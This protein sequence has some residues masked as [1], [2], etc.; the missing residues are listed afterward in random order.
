STITFENNSFGGTIY[1]W[2]FGIDGI[3]SDTSNEINPT[4]TFPDTG[5]YTVTLTVNPG[6]SCGD[7]TIATVYVFPTLTPSILAPDGCVGQPVQL[8]D[9][10]INTYGNLDSWFWNFDDSS[11]SDLINPEHVFDTAGD[12]TIQLIVGNSVGCEDTIEQLI[13]IFP[14]P[15]IN[16]TP[17]DTVICYLDN[18]SLL[19]SAIG[20]T[21]YNW[22]PDYNL[23]TTNTATTLA[24]PDESVTYTVT[25]SNSFGCIAQDSV[26]IEVFDTL[27]AFAGR[28]TTICPG[29]AVQLNGSGGINFSWSPPTGLN[30]TSIANPIANP[31]QT[32][33]YFLTTSVGSCVGSDTIT[34]FV[35][36]LP[37]IAAGPDESICQGDSVMISASGGT[38]YTWSPS[39][40]LNDPNSATPIASPLATTTYVVNATDANSCPFVGIDSLTVSVIPLPQI[41][42]S[43]DTSIILGTSTILTVIGGVSYQWIPSTGLDNAASATPTAAPTETTTYYVYI[44]T[45]DGCLAIDSI[46]ITVTL[47]PLVVFPTAFS[48]NNDGK[49]DLF[50]P[51]LLGLVNLSDFR[52]YNRWGEE[53]YAANNSNNFGWDGMLNGEPQEV[54]VYVY[55]LRGVATATGTM[56]SREGDF[57]LVR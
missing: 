5:V 19:A 4:Y 2:D 33:T 16:A 34:V 30:S 17:D 57:T 50:R 3:D 53:V 13:T 36:P 43:P 23:S 49:N 15:T 38:S 8:T 56:I 18:V 46:T 37:V 42:T 7:T 14:S 44:T 39:A 1:H 29:E 45:A 6:T 10:T 24:S 21:N 9:Q 51:V 11:T 52:I 48:P 32:T 54:G 20:A 25:V 27:I 35:K 26:H 47:E 22:E 12:Y 31:A 28:D 40:S 55:F 41:F